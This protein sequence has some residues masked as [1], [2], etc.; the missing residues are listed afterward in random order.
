M[1][2][3]NV[4]A[5]EYGI[6]KDYAIL[7]EATW[8]SDAPTQN[9]LRE[10]PY[11]SHKQKLPKGVAEFVVTSRARR[12]INDG[13][14]LQEIIDRIS[15]LNRSP[16]Q[17]QVLDLNQMLRTHDLK[18][19]TPSETRRYILEMGKVGFQIL[20]HAAIYQKQILKYE[21]DCILPRKLPEIIKQVN[22]VNQKSGQ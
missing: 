1:R 2:F 21:Y 9:E 18:W 15:N 16:H 19:G 10:V 12:A 20:K 6:S 8:H 11:Y 3:T 13:E 4:L 22:L 17:Q 7:V 14:D 5:D